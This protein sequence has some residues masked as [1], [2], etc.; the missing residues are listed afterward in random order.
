M[1]LEKILTDIITNNLDNTYTATCS[2]TTEKPL[3]Y[4]RLKKMIDEVQKN[5]IEFVMKSFVKQGKVVICDYEKIREESKIA[6]FILDD[7]QRGKVIYYN[8]LDDAIF[9]QTFPQYNFK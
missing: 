1:E 3:T 2:T 6:Q 5:K 9:R 8:P 7:N 4:D